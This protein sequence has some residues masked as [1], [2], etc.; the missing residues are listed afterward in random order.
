M[1]QKSIQQEKVK[2]VS[3]T[4]VVISAAIS[5]DGT[6]AKIFELL[7]ERKITNYATE[8]IIKEIEEVIARPALR[9]CIDENYK[10][11][12][13]NHFEKNSVIIKPT[14]S[15]KV[16]LKDSK[17]DKFVNCALSVKSNIISGDKHLLELTSFKGI[18]ILSAKEFLEIFKNK[19]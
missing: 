2:V 1:R 14:F 18:K 9:E 19:L 12:I 11:F 8:E 17:D 15:E 10:K 13:L 16:V 5:R 3:D 7:L 6:P 4:N